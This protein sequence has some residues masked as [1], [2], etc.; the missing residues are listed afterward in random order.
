[1]DELKVC[2][3]FAVVIPKSIDGMYGIMIAIIAY[4]VVTN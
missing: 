4:I 3:G 1:M 2:F